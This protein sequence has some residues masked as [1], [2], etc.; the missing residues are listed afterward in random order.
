MRR[1]LTALAIT[2]AVLFASAP[3]AMAGTLSVKG[4]SG[5]LNLW[6]GRLT[7]T[8]TACDDD[9]VYANWR[10][11]FGETIKLKNEIGC[12][13][14][15]LED[16]PLPPGK[17]TDVIWRVCVDKSWPTGDLCSGWKRETVYNPS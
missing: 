15:K 5:E 14:Y 17:Q 1:A 16:L 4:A 8:D 12:G 3:P 10:T 2:A 13:F 9:S 11:D 6:G 7:V